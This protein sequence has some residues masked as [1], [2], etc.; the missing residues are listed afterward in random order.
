MFT[1]SPVSDKDASLISSIVAV[2]FRLNNRGGYHAHCSEEE[3][4]NCGDLHGKELKI[5]V[6]RKSQW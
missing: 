3:K 4:A 6:L 5:V 1:H 2:G